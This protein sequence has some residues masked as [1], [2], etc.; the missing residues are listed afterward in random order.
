[1]L[2]INIKGLPEVLHPLGSL[3]CQETFTVITENKAGS[4][5]FRN[6]QQVELPSS[7][8]LCRTVVFCRCGTCCCTRTS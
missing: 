2:Q 7:A 4:H 1:M 3:V 8:V 5:I 6:K